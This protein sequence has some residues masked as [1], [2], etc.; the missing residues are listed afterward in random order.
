M[1]RTTSAL[2]LLLGALALSAQAA[3]PIYFKLD[4]LRASP[5]VKAIE[6]PPM[7]VYWGTQPATE[8]AEY[9][10]IQTYTRSGISLSPFGGSAR[11]CVEAFVKTLRDMVA[12]AKERGYDAVLDLRVVKDGKP[13][14]DPK[15]FYCTPGYK[16]TEVSLRGQFAMTAEAARRMAA[17]EER[18]DHLPPRPPAK[19]AIFLPLKPL[20]ASPEAAALAG[21]DIALYQGGDAPK[22]RD[23]FG[24]DTWSGK[25]ELGDQAQSDACRRAALDALKA[26]VASARE[27]KYDAVIRIR[28]FLDSA[29]PPVPTDYECQR[30]GRTVEVQF[31]ASLATRT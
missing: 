16:T 28:S 5:E 10:R 22:Y 6:Q 14:E 24:P 25:A 13:V 1:T 31:K 29:Y 8:F 7:L 26:M 9:S 27:R 15:G 23:R 19:D 12:D 2:A 20:L 18:L 11:H 21:A 3:D 30:D 17:D 4:E